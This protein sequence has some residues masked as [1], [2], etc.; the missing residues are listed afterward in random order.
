MQDIPLKSLHLELGAKMVEFAGYMMPIS[1][2]AG[3]MHEHLHT[4]EK[5]GLFDVSHMGQAVVS[6]DIARFEQIVPASIKNLKPGRMRYTQLTNDSG[7]IIDDLMVTRLVDA[8]NGEERLF[9]V[10]NGAR[11]DVDFAHISDNLSGL[12]QLADRALLALQGPLAAAV[13]H[14]MFPETTGMPF[15]SLRELKATEYGDLLIARCGYTGEDGFEIS[16]TAMEAEKLARDLLQN[17]AVEM[18]GLG[19]RDSLR[20]EAGL[21]LYGHDIDEN[22]SPIEAGLGWSVGKARRSSG[23]FPGDGRIL[24]ELSEGPARKLVGIKPEGRALAREGVEILNAGMEKIG[25]V[26]SGGYGP[27]VN[28]PIAMGY[29]PAEHAS[30]GSR[31][32]LLIRGKPQAAC[33]VSLPFVSHRYFR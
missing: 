24:Y 8:E 16:V 6:G 27:S 4:R 10:V 33:V 5:A 12:A 17:D 31:L 28:G 19:A 9:L 23:G 32:N 11:K 29:V 20:L 7:G 2:Q 18:I 14:K 25:V 26:T 1:Y 15:M 3:I 13:I 22:T 21:C 30:T